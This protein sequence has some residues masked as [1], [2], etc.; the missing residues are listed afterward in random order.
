[1]TDDAEGID[2]AYSVGLDGELVVLVVDGAQTV[3]RVRLP[4]H[5]ARR[6]ATLLLAACDV[7]EGDDVDE[8]IDRWRS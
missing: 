1:M 5:E 2:G 8:L 7:V 4:A 6:M 3:V